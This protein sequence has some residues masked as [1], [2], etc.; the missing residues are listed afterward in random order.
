MTKEVIRTEHA[1]PP[2]AVY[3]QAIKA[4]GFIF[5]AGQLGMNPVT[6]VYVDGGAKEQ[7]TQALKNIKAIVE[8]AGSDMSKVVKVT[9]YLHDMHDYAAMNEAYKE[10]FPSDPPARSAFQV[11]RLPLEARV[12][13]EA[14]ALV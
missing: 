9:V 3:S 6:R 8:A 13:I 12:E 10:F 7:V 5:T 2:A 11:A 4:N 1:P 14:I